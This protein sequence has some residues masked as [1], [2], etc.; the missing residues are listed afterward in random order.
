MTALEFKPE[1][2]TTCLTYNTFGNPTRWPYQ[3]VNPNLCASPKCGADLAQV[4]HAYTPIVYLDL[5]Q[6]GVF[7][8]TGPFYQVDQV[9][10][11][12]FP[13]GAVC[14]CGTLA[15]WWNVTS[16]DNAFRYAE[17]EI[18]GVIEAKNKEGE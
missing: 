13:N 9:A 6:A 8:K 5:P 15:Q 17:S 7:Q 11:F 2:L 1:L 18:K 3:P 16:P 14:N 12:R 4:F 10:W